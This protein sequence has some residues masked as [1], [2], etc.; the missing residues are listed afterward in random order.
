MRGNRRFRIRGGL[1]IRITGAPAQEL[2][3]EET[4]VSRVAV[5][6][7]AHRG[8]RPALRVEVGQSVTKGEIVFVDRDRPA[9]TFTAP[10]AGVV[11]EIRRG[12]G[13]RV[14]GVV[15]ELDTSRP[16]SAVRVPTQATSVRQALLQHG[17]WPALVERPLGV[18]PDPDAAPDDILV[19]AIDTHPLAVDPRL[20]IGAHAAAFRSGVEALRTLTMGRVLVCQGAG[21]LLAEDA[22]V[23][24][25]RHPAGLPGTHVQHLT[26]LG[27]GVDDARVWHVG[28]QDVIAMGYL[29]E[30]GVLW[31]ERVI[32]VGGPS[33]RRPGLVR[34]TLGAALTEVLGAENV[35][36]D[37]LLIS[38]SALDGERREFLGRRH[39]QIT[40][41]PPARPRVPGVIVPLGV[42]DRAAPRCTAPTALLRALSAGDDETARRLGVRSMLEEDVALLSSACTSQVRYEPLLR[43]AIERLHG[44]EPPPIGE[45]LLDGAPYLSLRSSKRW[46]ALLGPLA[47]AL[48]LLAAT[49][50]R[51]VGTLVTAATLVAV[52]V[53][54]QVLF[55]RLRPRGMSLSGL[56]TALSL[57]VLAPPEAPMWQLALGA[58]FGVVVAEEVFGGYGYHFVQPAL[59]GYAFLA[60]SFG[61]V[62]YALP[63]VPWW[64][65]VPGAVLLL[66]GEVLSWRVLLAATASVVATA[67]TLGAALPPTEAFG[68]LAFVLVFFAGDPVCAATTDPGR[69]LYGAFIGVL[70]ALGL[71]RGLESPIFPVLV[72][73][74][75]APAIDAFII[76]L[77]ERWRLVR[78]A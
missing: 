38:G 30:E 23:F 40:A 73:Q 34:A 66:L 9:I 63:Q 76:R 43:S 48:P 7:E 36:G 6:A 42:L 69:W 3:Q 49:L 75:F 77:A 53:A 60:F 22:V 74:I 64:S 13:R 4:L 78:H 58:S 46:M 39:L 27:R 37:A 21:P 44:R 18:L 32:S 33:V 47:L 57:A 15:L 20:V 26:A 5:D 14:V 2:A 11:R 67:L 65:I 59:A 50:E 35:E 61:D 8:V 54:W 28:Y 71:D 55:A 29:L 1:S 41:L 68:A 12:A 45:R 24:E 72:A 70:I 19:T 51:G 56:A 10:E 62:A 16:S 52:V 31:T 25:G 17:L